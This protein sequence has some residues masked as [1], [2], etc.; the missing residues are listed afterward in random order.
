ML[1]DLC[2]LYRFK[3]LKGWL[4]SELTEKIEGWNTKV[5]EASG[6]MIAVT[7]IK[8]DWQ[9]PSGA[10]FEDYLGMNVMEDVV[11][12]IPV[13]LSSMGNKNAAGK[14]VRSLYSREGY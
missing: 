9:I 5:Y 8:S 1:V 14:D 11:V 3:P 13:N 12:E 2:V 7:H 6:K 10:S 4:T